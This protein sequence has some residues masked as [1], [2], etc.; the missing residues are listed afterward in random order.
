MLVDREIREKLSY[1]CLVTRQTQ[2]RAANQALR[3]L[4]ERAENDPATKELMDRA[5]SLKAAID[6]LCQPLTRAAKSGE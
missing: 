1:Y 5:K 3:A 6:A 4:L 2:E